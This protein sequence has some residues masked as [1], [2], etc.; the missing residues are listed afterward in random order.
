MQTSLQRIEMRG[1]ATK[2]K[3]ER[4]EREVKTLHILFLEML[5][6]N[7]TEIVRAAQK[8]YKSHKDT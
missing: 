5:N 8:Q 2:E 4:R 6:R 7:K 1:R 3:T